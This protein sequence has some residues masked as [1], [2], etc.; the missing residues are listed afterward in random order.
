MYLTIEVETGNG[1]K[2]F[3][4]NHWIKWNKILNMG[5]KI[6]SDNKNNFYNYL[7]LM[8]GYMYSGQLG[9]Q[10][11]FFELIDQSRF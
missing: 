10:N 5:F 2:E 6:S 9:R 11:D 3:L 4:D 8:R 7:H 1:D